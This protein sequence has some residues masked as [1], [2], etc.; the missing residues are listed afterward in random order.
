MKKLSTLLALIISVSAFSQ[1]G[2]EINNTSQAKL[3]GH[4][5][6]DRLKEAPFDSWFIPRYDTFSIQKPKR[7]EVR[8]ALANV[9][10]IQIFFGTWCGDSK[11]EVPKFLKILKEVGF[12]KYNLIGLDHTFQNYKQS[13]FGE[14]IGLGIHRV[15]TIIFYN[16]SSEIGRIVEEPV[17]SLEQDTYQILTTGEYTPSY[18]I[19]HEVQDILAEKGADYLLYHVDAIAEEL[20]KK[21]ETVSALSTYALVLLTSFEIKA[22]EAVYILNTKLFSEEYYPYY[23][24]GRYYQRIGNQQLAKLAY[25]EG[26]LKNPENERL[27]A[28]LATVK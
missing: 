4:V 7:K 10:S 5:E 12:T 28:Q 26:L 2:F 19:V 1:K 9:D 15:P 16:D 22:S 8:K 13:P 3:L 20:S 25:S 21:A 6:V 24:L 14:E 11:R 18:D 17:V 23:G 27:L